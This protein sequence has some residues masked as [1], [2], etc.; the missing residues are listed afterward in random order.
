MDGTRRRAARRA[1]A[2]ALV[3]LIG[4]APVERGAVEADAD[5]EAE[6]EAD[7]LSPSAD[8]DQGAESGPQTADRGGI[9]VGTVQFG[10]GAG[11]MAL[12]AIGLLALVVVLLDRALTKERALA[13]TL[14][15]ANEDRGLGAAEK[16][17][18]MKRSIQ[19]GV[20]ERLDRR[21]HEVRNSRG[22]E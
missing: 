11:V 9:N 1:A 12:C 6:V 21:V 14:I 22:A 17:A 10:A 16:A 3:P 13:D 2:L 20:G 8:T 15:E 5:V 7:V 18:I 4:C 19:R